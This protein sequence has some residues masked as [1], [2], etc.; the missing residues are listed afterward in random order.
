MA[1]NSLRAIQSVDPQSDSN[2][3]PDSDHSDYGKIFIEE[4]SPSE[5]SNYKLSVFGGVEFGNP[6]VSSYFTGIEAQK[7]IHPLV[8]MS[9]D[10]SFYETKTHSTVKAMK[11]SLPGLRYFL[12][13]FKAYQLL[14]C[15]LS[16]F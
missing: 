6:Y 8:Y 2:F 12:S 15:E 5:D 16:D 13:L 14:E 10:Y 7:K 4:T 9:L 1:L 3:P 11:K